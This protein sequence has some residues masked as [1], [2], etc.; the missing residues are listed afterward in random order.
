ML[1]IW[2]NGVSVVVSG[3]FQLLELRTGGFRVGAMVLVGQASFGVLYAK[4]NL[5]GCR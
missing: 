4:G 5:F 2:L 3:N 1:V